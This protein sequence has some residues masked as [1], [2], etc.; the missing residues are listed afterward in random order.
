MYFDKIH[1]R[2]TKI[3]IN[4]WSTMFLLK[5]VYI[6][7]VRQFG[8]IRFRESLQ[9]IV[10]FCVKINLAKET[11]QIFSINFCFVIFGITCG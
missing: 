11:K 2:Y 10:I 5:S 1:S 8:G 9:I 7:M 3:T 4:A 6:N